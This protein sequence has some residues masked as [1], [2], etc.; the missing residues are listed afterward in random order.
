MPSDKIH[1][2]VYNLVY[3]HVAK[4]RDSDEKLYKIALARPE[5]SLSAPLTADPSIV[6]TGRLDRVVDEINTSRLF[7]FE[8]KTV[9]GNKG[10]AAALQYFE[11][12]AFLDRQITGSVWLAHKALGMKVVGIYYDLLV[13]GAIPTYGR[14]GPILR[15]VQDLDDWELDALAW[16]TEIEDT[17]EYNRQFPDKW[18]YGFP[19]NT[20]N[21]I[22]YFGR[23]CPYHP[24]CITGRH[25]LDDDGL[26]KDVEWSSE[27]VEEVAP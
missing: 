3:G 25:V 9:S 12:R 20:E 22:G 10:L 4:W 16:Q 26:Y 13:K 8:H 27:V 5:L 17:L 21:C 23:E 1:E 6:W 7:I 19:R 14:V 24:V 2:I 11:R 15:S 18:R